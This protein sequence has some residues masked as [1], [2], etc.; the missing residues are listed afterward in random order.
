MELKTL[1]FGY[2]MGLVWGIYALFL[3][4]VAWLF[5]WG[6]GLVQV[7]STYYIGF[8]PTLSGALIGTVWALVDGFI[9]GLILAAIYNKFVR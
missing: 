1:K 6:V 2:A 5:G 9:F 4:L 3:G 8:A 7:L